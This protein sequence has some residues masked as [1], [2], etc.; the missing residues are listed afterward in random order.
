MKKIVLGLSLLLA[1]GNILPANADA[2]LNKSDYTRLLNVGNKILKT[3]NID[4]KILF[5]FTSVG[6]YGVMPIAIDTSHSHDYNLHNNR[7]VNVY[8]GDYF[9]L[10]SDE[11]LAALLAPEIAQGV[12]SYTGLLN[13]QFFFT[14]NG[15]CPFNAIAK[16]NELKF[17]KQAVDYLVS[18]GYNPTTLITVYERLLPE[19]RGTFWGRHNKAEKRINNIKKY[20][21]EKYPQYL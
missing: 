8:L 9:K 13:G 18:A 6:N 21:N 17:D 11:E 20:I 4:K 10:N 16:R 5:N 19:W 14:K 2:L 1:L 15:A 12:H 3:N 7:V